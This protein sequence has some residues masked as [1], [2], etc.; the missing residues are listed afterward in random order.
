MGR[1]SKITDNFSSESNC[2]DGLYAFHEELGCGGFGKV[3]LAIHMLTGEKVA[4]KII[5]KKAIGVC[6]GGVEVG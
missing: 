3:K 5:D 6:W 1:K 2:M 4:V